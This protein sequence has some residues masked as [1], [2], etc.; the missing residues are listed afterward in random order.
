MKKLLF[1]VALTLV[2]IF[3]GVTTS[4]AATSSVTL[5]W[6]ANTE[7]DLA[8]YKLYSGASAGGPYVL[9]QTLAKVTGTTVAGLAD[10]TYHFV[11]TAFDTFSNESGY[12]NEVF[13]TF[14]TIP[15]LAP[16]NVVIT[17]TVTVP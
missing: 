6:D 14:D 3:I 10:G 1:L 9:K 13:K 8:G 15:P 11:L 2:G 4:S 16:R 5:A 17:I 7:P 12:S